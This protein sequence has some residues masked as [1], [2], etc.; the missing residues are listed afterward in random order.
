MA[1][2]L[3]RIMSA[4]FG[5]AP[6]DDGADAELIKELVEET[7]NEVEPRVRLNPGYQGKLAEGVRATI[8][9]L[10]RLGQELPDTPIDLTAAAW[11][12][13]P[14]VNAFFASKDEV[15]QFLGRCKPLRAL[16]K[17]AGNEA[18][19]DAYGLL[20][21]R[22]DEKQVFAPKMEDGM[23]K[24]DVA[25]TSVSFSGHRLFGPAPTRLEARRE[26]GRLIF[27]RL[28]QIA[29]KQ[30]I[31]L[32]EKAVELNQRKGYLGAR[33][34]LLRLAQDGME[35]IVQDPASIDAQIKDVERELKETVDGYV[36]AKS[37]L[38]TL[39]G[40]IGLIN[41]VLCHPD[42][43]VQ[44]EPFTLRV[45]RMGLKV[46]GDGEPDAHTLQLY[47]MRIGDVQ[48]VVAIARIPRSEIPPEEDLIANAERYL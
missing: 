30:I 29:L 25:Q 27:H 8:A 12:D 1:S 6:A 45:N 38:S 34:R 5:G 24:Q 11:R 14:R 31:A 9:Y 7:V 32:D 18:L 37:N 2:A 43:H 36:E 48:G 26:V 28:A 41:D 40:Y 23:L 42:Q 20:G 16:F 3:D 4:L 47:R 46:E 44:V 22:L 21:M 15:P 39:D 13:D 33:M 10:R 17:Q 35:G 19:Q